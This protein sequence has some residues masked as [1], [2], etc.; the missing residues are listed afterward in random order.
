MIVGMIAEFADDPGFTVVVIDDECVRGVLV[1]FVGDMNVNA[2]HARQRECAAQQQC[3]DDAGRCHA[4]RIIA[5]GRRH[6]Q[7]LTKHG[8]YAVQHFATPE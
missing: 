6:G 2:Q 5:C 7:A 4:A 1:R 3:E 8:R